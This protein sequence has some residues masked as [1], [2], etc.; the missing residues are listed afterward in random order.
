[1]VE[2]L[3]AI[4]EQSQRL[5]TLQKVLAKETQALLANDWAG[6]QALAA[7]KIQLFR[8]ISALESQRQGQSASPAQLLRRQ[9]ALAQVARHNQQNGASIQ[10][11]GRFQQ[12]AWQILFGPENKLYGD[13]GQMENDK[14]GHRL[15]SA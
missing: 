6:I 8:E 2:P 15:G 4:D 11:L 13:A 14:S 5:E 10:A 1:M 7:Q 12:E 9:Q 3:A